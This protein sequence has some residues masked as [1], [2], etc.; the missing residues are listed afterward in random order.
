MESDVTEEGKIRIQPVPSTMCLPFVVYQDPLFLRQD[1]P[2]RHP[3]PYLSHWGSSAAGY[4]AS[5]TSWEQDL[6]EM[7]GILVF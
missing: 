3:E 6:L 7:G 2:A 5:L 1:T 4:D